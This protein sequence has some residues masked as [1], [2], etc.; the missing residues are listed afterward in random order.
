M[1]S[2][3]IAAAC[4]PDSRATSTLAHQVAGLGADRAVTP[5]RYADDDA[6]ARHRARAEGDGE[7]DQITIDGMVIDVG[8]RHQDLPTMPPT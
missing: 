5:G 3:M 2:Q 1:I 7:Q 4:V 6:R 8:E